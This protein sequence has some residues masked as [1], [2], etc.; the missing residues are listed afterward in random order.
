MRW[1]NVGMAIVAVL[2]VTCLV[3]A[4]AEIIKTAKLDCKNQICLHWWPKLP[5]AKGWHTDMDANYQHNFNTL[6]PDGFTFDN[7][8]AIIYANAIYKPRYETD[9]PGTKSL[10]QFIADDQKTFTSRYKQEAVTETAPLL[11]QDGQKLRSFTY[12]R[13]G[14]WERVS[15]GEE[16]EYYLLFVINAY[17]EIG[18]RRNQATYENTI[19]TYRR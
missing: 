3:N 12:F 5:A 10:D 1:T 17:S 13:P 7:A 2:G 11:T 6:V 14:S 4:R 16:G 19:R 18:Y 8:D 15:Y 9:Y